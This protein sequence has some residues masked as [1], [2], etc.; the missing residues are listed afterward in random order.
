MDKQGNVFKEAVNQDF[1]LQLSDDLLIL[2]LS[3]L[4]CDLKFLCGCM[5]IS[6]RFALLIPLISSVTLSIPG[7]GQD[8]SPFKFFEAQASYVSEALKSFQN[9]RFLHLEFV[10]EKHQEFNLQWKA[11]FGSKTYTC[12]SLVFD[13]ITKLSASSPSGSVSAF[14]QTTMAT[15]DGLFWRIF[16]PNMWRS[17]LAIL[18]PMVESVVI[19]DSRRQGEICFGNS[20][21]RDARPCTSILDV[22]NNRFEEGRTSL[23]FFWLPELRLP[24]SGF[25]MKGVSLVIS[26]IGKN[27]PEDHKYD[28]MLNCD[29]RDEHEVFGEAM[30]LI[31]RTPEDRLE[32]CLVYAHG[33]YISFIKIH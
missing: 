12:A 17:L 5:L 7:S 11:V 26:K 16:Y 31:L 30:N 25:L 6:K 27:S 4:N 1:I 21:L 2:I 22:W 32:D 15:V 8:K 23:K 13:Y 9:I 24:K 28:D 33:I 3:M 14:S 10:E 19:T 18:Q 29:F 20:E